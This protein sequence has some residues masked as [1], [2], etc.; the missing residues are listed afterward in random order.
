[1]ALHLTCTRTVAWS[2][3]RLGSTF[4]RFKSL[5]RFA[6]ILLIKKKKKAM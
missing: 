6:L 2:L 4:G 3:E 1:M 5:A